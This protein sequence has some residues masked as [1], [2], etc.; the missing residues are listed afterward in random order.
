MGMIIFFLLAIAYAIVAGIGVLHRSLSV[1]FAYG[2]MAA[3]ILYF[4]LYAFRRRT[5]FSLT[6]LGVVTANLAVQLTGGYA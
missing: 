4:V 3:V 5:P 6:I 1:N 2:A